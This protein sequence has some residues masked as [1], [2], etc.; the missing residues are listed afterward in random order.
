MYNYNYNDKYNNNKSQFDLSLSNFKS[1]NYQKQ[2]K[3]LGKL[4]LHRMSYW[5]LR[6]KYDLEFSVYFIEEFN[7]IQLFTRLY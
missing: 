4:K 6:E 2:Q 1:D 5:Y 7:K 3:T